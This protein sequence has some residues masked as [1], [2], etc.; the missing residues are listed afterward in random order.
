[1]ERNEDWYKSKESVDRDSWWK[2]ESEIEDNPFS[3][4]DTK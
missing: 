3:P 4:V 1:M 2:D